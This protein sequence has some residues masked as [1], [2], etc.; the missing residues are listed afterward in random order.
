MF[1]LLLYWIMVLVMNT[2]FV[3]MYMQPQINGV[4]FQLLFFDWK[5]V[6]SIIFIPIIAVMPDYFW[7]SMFWAMYPTEAQKLLSS[8]KVVNA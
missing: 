3:A 4:F 6:M 1:S 7:N 8:R 2:N 5:G